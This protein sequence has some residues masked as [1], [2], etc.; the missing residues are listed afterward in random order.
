MK[1]EDAP[2]LP[3]LK[4]NDAAHTVEVLPEQHFTQ[5]P[6]RYSEASLIKTLEELGI[7]RP[8]TYAP[9]LDTIVICANRVRLC[10]GRLLDSVL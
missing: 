9:I 6:P 10:G 2:Q 4:K 7:G 3:A 5:P 8:S 1:K